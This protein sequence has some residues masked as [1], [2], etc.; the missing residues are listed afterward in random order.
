[1]GKNL[2][3]AQSGGPTSAINA[4]LSGVIEQ[5][6]KEGSID[7]V[8]GAKHGIVGV[9]NEDLINLTEAFADPKEIERLYYTPASALG[10]CRHKLKKLT[11]DQ[12][13]YHTILNTLVK[14]NIGYFVYIGGNDSMDTV[15]KLN[16]FFIANDHKDILAI[17][18]PKTIDN[19]LVI[20]DHCPGYGSAAKY[21]GTTLAEI[22]RDTRAYNSKTLTIV[23]IMGR[24]A[25]W[26]TAA[27]ALSRIHGNKGPDFI[28]LCEVVFDKD[29]FIEDVKSAFEKSNTVIVAVSEGIK[30]KTGGYVADDESILGMKKSGNTD[31][32]GHSQLSGACRTLGIYAS[33]KIGCKVRPIELSS[34][35]RCAAH[36]ASATDLAESKQLGTLAVKSLM[37]GEGNVMITVERVSSKPYEV[38]YSKAPVSQIA[39]NEKKVPR[40]WINEAGNDITQELMDYMLPLI[41]GQVPGIYENGIPNYK[42]LFQ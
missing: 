34:V 25:G 27:S 31:A 4:S 41:Q 12:S 16:Q 7:T 19:D 24:N 1:M 29:K 20:T 23:E 10:T 5:A 40:E 22:E 11:E 8:Y 38:K 14:Y 9:L 30:D 15:D 18:V 6:L 35:Q 39:N 37:E 28:Y 32:F 21:I 17:G 33:E 42:V 3:V 13:E 26:L 36:I 2:L